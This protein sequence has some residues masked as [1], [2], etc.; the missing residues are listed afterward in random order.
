ME[1]FK[2]YSGYPD[3]LVDWNPTSLFDWQT[4]ARSYESDTYGALVAEE[5][6]SPIL[7]QAH[8]LYALID[9]V[10]AMEGR[11]VFT[12]REQEWD[13]GIGEPRGMFQRVLGVRFVLEGAVEPL[14][15]TR[16][17]LVIIDGAW[18]LAAKRSLGI[19]LLWLDRLFGLVI[20]CGIAPC[21]DKPI[22][23]VPPASAGIMNDSGAKLFDFRVESTHGSGD[24]QKIH[25][26]L[27]NVRSEEIAEIVL[28]SGDGGFAEALEE[29]VREGI[30]VY[31]IAAQKKMDASEESNLQMSRKFLTGSFRLID[32][33]H[34]VDTIG[35]TQQES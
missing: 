23:L 8:A 10:A 15:F 28:L 16:K 21:S 4:I 9:R 20:S 25:D 24:D 12:Y 29:K 11:K 3:L 2:I 31:V 27:K 19:A 22:F 13:D 33:A 35:K 1:G 6:Q 34:W 17:K 32:L 5:P 7:D 30:D 18:L 26:I 14:P